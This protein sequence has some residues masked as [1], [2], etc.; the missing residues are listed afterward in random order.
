MVLLKNEAVADSE[1]PL[2][3]LK[4]GQ[5]GKIAVIGRLAD[6]ANTGDRGSSMVRPPYVV[7]PLAGIR[8][9]VGDVLFG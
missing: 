5:A 9:A 1:Q 8:A 2:L 6:I 7:T 4:G 3:P